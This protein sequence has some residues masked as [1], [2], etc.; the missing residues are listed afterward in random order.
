MKVL[1]VITGLNCG[2]AENL[3]LEICKEQKKRGFSQ[4]VIYLTKREYLLDAFLN[5]GI[6][7]V[8]IDVQKIGV[9]RAIFE[10][11]K[12]VKSFSPDI[13]NTHLVMADSLTRLACL[14][15]KNIK[16]F[17]SIHSLDDW[18]NK[19]NISSVFMKAFNRFTI[20]CIKNYYL[21]AVS[22]SAK[23]FCIK[24]EKIKEEKIFVLYNFT[25]IDPNKSEIPV[26]RQQLGFEERDFVLINV[27]RLVPEK[28]QITLLRA[29]KALKDD[30][31]SNVKAIILGDGPLREKLELFIKE[32]GLEGT[33]LLPGFMINTY[34][35]M[36]ISDLFVLTSL[37]E[38]F[39]LVT[40]EAFYNRVPVV[41]GDMPT[42][43]ELITNRE[44]GLFYPVGDIPALT[45]TIKDI[46]EGKYDL[47]SFTDKAFET[48]Q[49][50]TP[51]IFFE[52]LE[53]IYG[54]NHKNK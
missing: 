9:I 17:S 6:E 19:N 31:F 4:K 28:S 39:S 25:S 29:V 36:K 42:I 7:T 10:I 2:G 46:I 40:V 11:R 51:D 22:K 24:R 47:K 50:F 12:Q 5:S 38:G 20:N 3:L 18:K 54:I 27:G 30:G 37:I 16:L 53:K 13:I 26:T 1:S 45:G 48:Y 23:D 21:I 44:S 8:L 32:N 49:K 15:L 52:N 35:Y 33:V 14:W 43:R 41:S 34:S